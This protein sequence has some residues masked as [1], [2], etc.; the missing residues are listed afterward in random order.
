MFSWH[1]NA[2]VVYFHRPAW[3][4]WDSSAGC[5]QN[6]SLC[7]CGSLEVLGQS[8]AGRGLPHRALCAIE[9]CHELPPGS[10]SVSSY[11]CR[12]QE[13]SCFS[14]A[15]RSQVIWLCQKLVGKTRNDEQQ[16]S[17]LHD[18]GDRVLMQNTAVVLVQKNLCISI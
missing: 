4:P 17:F 6:S 9:S 18:S 5:W 14:F 13:K 16:E 1:R 10:K 12:G 7:W 2:L 8:T 15:R 3:L 11:Q